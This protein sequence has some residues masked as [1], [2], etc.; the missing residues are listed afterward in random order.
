MNFIKLTKFDT[1]NGVGI[2][3]VL[4]VAGCEH[5]CQGCHN[6]TTWDRR[7]GIEFTADTAREI[8]DDL[9]APY[10][11]G[12]TFSGGDPLAPYNR[13][14][15]FG[16][17]V[18]IRK[19]YGMEKTIWCYTGYDWEEIKEWTQLGVFDVVVDGKFILDQRNISLPYCG[20]SN[21]RVIDVQQ[22]LQ[23]NTIVLWNNSSLT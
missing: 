18:L 16:L 12:I 23:K 11:H 10:R 21:Q 20:S 19:I 2:R 5:H 7:C 13:E 14:A 6:P 17:A 22:S 8:L 15:I 1:A 4:W 3:E 9:S